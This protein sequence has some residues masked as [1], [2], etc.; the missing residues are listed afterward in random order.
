MSYELCEF[1][2]KGCLIVD[3]KYGKHFSITDPKGVSTVIYR[4]NKTEK[5]YLEKSPKFTIERLDFLEEIRG[6]NKKKTFFVENPKVAGEELIILSFADGKVIINMGLLEGDKIK[7]GKKPARIKYD[8]LYTESEEEYKIFQYTPNLR[9]PISII[10]PETTEEVK[11][12]VFID[13]DTKEVRGKCKIK[14]FKPYF[15]F[16]VREDKR[17]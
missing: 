10:D 12:I 14:P 4:I 15:T 13:K 1:I 8:T 17:Y 6:E 2:E 9:R 11:P 7:I 5:E 16:E 3:F